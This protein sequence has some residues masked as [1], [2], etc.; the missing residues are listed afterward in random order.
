VKRG[1]WTKTQ[2]L[3]LESAVEAILLEAKRIQ[4]E[5][6]CLSL[7][8]KFR[9]LTLVNDVDRGIFG[10]E[11]NWS[12]SFELPEEIFFSSRI[13]VRLRCDKSCR[14]RPCDWLHRLVN[15]GQPTK[16]W[17]VLVYVGELNQ[18]LEL[19]DVYNL[20]SR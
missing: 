6:D 19:R 14:N 7:L 8:R 13:I 20:S 9:G 1:E 18:P 17:P 4:A 11:R 5:V 12:V 2:A 16:T 3:V 15:I 10:H